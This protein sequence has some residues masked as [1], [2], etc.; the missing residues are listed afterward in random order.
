MWQDDAIEKLI[1]FCVLTA[2]GIYGLR[3][4]FRAW[5]A[6]RAIEN[7]PTSRVRSAAQGYVELVGVGRSH[8]ENIGPLTG[9]PCTWWSFAI[10]ERR[11]NGRSRSWFTVRRGVSE[12]PFYLDD[13]TGECLIDPRGAEVFPSGKDV[14]R[15]ATAWPSNR[16]VTGSRGFSGALFGGD[17]RYTEHRMRPGE[18]VYAIGLFRSQRG[19]TGIDTVEAT[20]ALLREWKQ[21]QPALLQRFDSNGDGVLGAR[22]WERARLIARESVIAAEAARP[23]RPEVNMLSQPGDGRAFLLAASDAGA[24][25]RRYRWRAAGGIAVFLGATGAVAWAVVNFY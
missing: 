16:I 17:F 22:E 6:G 4:G 2:A 15:G 5:A 3:A 23:P 7:T 8:G 25:A 12:M 14:W 1:V 11:S 19:V 21:D 20:A 10:E 24:L 9:L 13:S 18:P